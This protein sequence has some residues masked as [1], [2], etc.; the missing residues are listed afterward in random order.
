MGLLDLKESRRGRRS[1][2]LVLATILIIVTVGFA[3]YYSITST[4]LSDLQQQVSLLS[5][6]VKEYGTLR[7]SLQSL[8]TREQTMIS[9]LQ[10]IQ[11]RL[12]S[13]YEQ[14]QAQLQSSRALSEGQASQIQQLKSGLDDVQSQL[15]SLQTK[16]SSLQPQMPLTTLVITGNSYDSAGGAESFIVQNTFSGSV[17]AQL[18][19]S[20]RCNRVGGIPLCETTP[21]GSYTSNVVQFNPS[22]T[23]V[24]SFKLSEIHWIYTDH[25]EPSNLEVYLIAARTPVSQTYVFQFPT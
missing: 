2:A 14:L 8:Q 7:A 9:Q 13:N 18:Q 16:Y 25:I 21:M 17:Y 6:Q 1:L 19:V 22:S 5:Q 23:T 12:Q 10:S 4:T 11:S 3:Y 15:R 20:V 24:V